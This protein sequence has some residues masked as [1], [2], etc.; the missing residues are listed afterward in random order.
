[1]PATAILRYV[2]YCFGDLD[3]FRFPHLNDIEAKYQQQQVFRYLFGYLMADEEGKLY[4]EAANDFP[5]PYNFG[6]TSFIDYCELRADL[7]GASPIKAAYHRQQML[8]STE[9]INPRWERADDEMRYF[10]AKEW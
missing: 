9:Q 8:A 10:N 6:I 7:S 3:G 5:A 1:M 4:F 2:G